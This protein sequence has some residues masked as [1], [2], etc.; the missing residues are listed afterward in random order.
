M[1][2]L[3]RP[4]SIWSRLVAITDRFAYPL[5]TSHY[6][7]LIEP[8]WASHTL[9]ARVESVWDETKDARTLTLRPGLRWRTHRAGQHLRVGVSLGGMQHTRTF[10]ISS[11]PERDDGCITITVKA[12]AGGLVSTYLVRK[13]QV[14]T[15]LP[16]AL[17]QGDFFLPDS[18][19]VKPLFITAGSGVTPAASMLAS[20]I[21]QDRLPDTVHIHY[22]PHAHDVIFENK[23]RLMSE[24]QPRYHLKSVFTHEYGAL[25]Q[26][27]GYF[28]SEQLDHLCPDWRERDVYACGPQPLLAAIESHYKHAGMSRQLHIERFRA[29]LAAIPTEAVGGRVRFVKS[30]CGAIADGQTSLLRIAEDAG[31]NPRHGCRMGICRM[32]DTRLISGCIRD[33]RTGRLRDETGSIIQTCV[34]T[35]A[36][37]CELDL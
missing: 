8:L 37:D 20:L 30:R 13:L 24:T 5:R 9:Q 34:S 6:V 12:I 25:K 22:A 31:L 1:T 29:N 32:C 10:T 15:Y 19:P 14:G 11:P 7:E 27:K 21:A 26:T 23:L 33:L 36:G 2:T 4:R 17:P 16:I 28:S 3:L 18:R 35:N